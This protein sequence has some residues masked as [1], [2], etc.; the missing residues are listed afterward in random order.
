M[1]LAQDQAA[2][3]ERFRNKD[4]EEWSYFLE[5]K[6]K[7]LHDAY[8]AGYLADLPRQVGESKLKFQTKYV[9][10]YREAV[11]AETSRFNNFLSQQKSHLVF[12]GK[13]WNMAKRLYFG[14]RGV[15][16]GDGTGT[17]TATHL[18]H[19][20]IASNENFLRMR[21]KLMPNPHFDPHLQASANRDN[22]QLETTAAAAAS[23]SKKKTS[24]NA[25]AAA[26]SKKDQ[27]KK[28]LQWQVVKEAV[29]KGQLTGITG[30][31]IEAEEDSLTEEDL[32]TIAIEQMETADDTANAAG[33]ADAKASERLLLSADCQLV[34]FMSV[35]KGKS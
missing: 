13:R 3:F 2:F 28:L 1:A 32:K 16:R 8:A 7:P 27:T 19:W 33:S 29:K 18:E 12:I 35:V 23:D 5:K 34:T 17:S 26:E 11:K 22:V 4:Q 20:K 15:W 25:A 31:A 24:S 21:M 9:E 6:V 10:P 30:G 14:P